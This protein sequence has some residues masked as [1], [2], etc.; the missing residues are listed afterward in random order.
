MHLIKIY[1][2]LICI[3]LYACNTGTKESA[4]EESAS[5]GTASSENPQKKWYK[6]NLHTHS[7]WSDGDDFPEMI[8]DWYKSHGYDFIV[9]SDHNTLQV[10]EK[11]KLIPKANI[12]QEGLQ[13]YIDKYGED[14]VEHKK[15]SAG[16]TLVKLKTLEEYRPLF[17]EEGK[18]L[19][20]QSE[21]VTDGF[22]GKPIHMNVTNIQTLIEPQGGNSVAEVMQNNIDQVL[23]Q[24]ESTGVPM[25]PHINHP[26]FGWAITPEDMMQ[27]TGE[28][29]F[30]VYNGHPAVHNYG[31]SLRP[32]MDVLWDKV[33]LSYLLAGKPLLYGLA[34][35]DAHN[36]HV[37][38]D[39]HSNTGRGWV[40]VHAE[41]LT[42]NAM[43][44]AMERGDFYA[45]TGVELSDVTFDGEA[46]SVKVVAETDIDYTIQF[47]GAKSTDEKGAELLKEVKDTEA[48]YMLQADDLYVRAKI[49]STKIKENPYKVGDVEM[50]WVQPVKQ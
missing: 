8:M 41:E 15:D 42:P 48:S 21:E 38:D 1:L 32:N 13:E 30:E 27:L 31:D 37:F 43:V 17:E 46:L 47:I 16:S 23:Q 34:T 9:L 40:M 45:S 18:F 50:A 29:F 11:W 44:E 39:E 22:E 3:G 10:G 19:I 12:Y 7:Y 6:G 14:W 24:R 25:F 28:R 4:S 33:Q 5:E 2:T 36:Y 35:D 49:I 20:I 26:N